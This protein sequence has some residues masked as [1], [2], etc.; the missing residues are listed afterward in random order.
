[1]EHWEHTN[2]GKYREYND[3]GNCDRNVALIEDDHDYKH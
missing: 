2:G 3:I 1:M